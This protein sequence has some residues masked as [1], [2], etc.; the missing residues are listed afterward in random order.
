MKKSE[1]SSKPA[2]VPPLPSDKSPNLSPPDETPSVTIEPTEPTY[3]QKRLQELGITPEL[4]QQTAASFTDEYS[5]QTFPVF[6][7]N[8]NGDILIRYAGINGWKSYFRGKS[9]EAAYIRTRLHPSRCTDGMPK[10]LTPRGAGT[11][12]FFPPLILEAY[13][14]STEIKTLVVTEG[15]FKAFKA[16]IHGLFCVG[17]QGIHNTHEKDPDGGNILNTELQ[18]VIRICKVKNLIFLLDNDCLTVE[19]EED[20][21]LA[22]RP[23]LF[24]SAVRNFREYTKHLDCDVYFAHLNP[25][26]PE[27]G[28]DDLLCAKADK[29]A[30]IIEE[31]LKLKVKNPYFF[32]ENVTD[33]SLKKLKSYFAL[34]NADAFYDKY[35]EVLTDKKFRFSGHYYQFNGL[36]LKRLVSDA[37]NNF[38]RV[39]DDYYEAYHK[40]D[41]EERMELVF[42]KRK[43]STITD[44]Y[45]K[46]ATQF[47]KRYKGFCLVPSHHNYR[48]EINQ[49]YNT[50]Y[51]LTHQPQAG[52]I[53]NSLSLLRHIFGERIEFAVDYMQLLYQRPAQLLPILLLQSKERETG[54]STFGQWLRD[55]FE[56]NSVKL[57]NA[58]LQGDFNSS[59]MEKLLIVVDETS[60]ERKT[61]SE[62]IKRMSTEV[63]KVIVKKKSVAEYE[64]D[65]IGKFVF[66]TNNVGTSLYIGKGETRYAVF[67]VPPFPKEKKDPDMLAKLREE[68]P[69]FLHH[70]QGRTLHYPKIGRMYFDFE[71][72]KTDELDEAIEAN[73]P[74]VEREIRTYIQDCFDTWPYL[75]ELFF[76]PKDLVDELK[77]N[78]KFIDHVSV[79]RTLKNDLEYLPSKESVRYQFYSIRVFSQISDGYAPSSRVGKCYCVNRHFFE[80]GKVQI[81]EPQQ[82]IPF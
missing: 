15:E 40:P 43:K 74:I 80:T 42:D 3:F 47:I 75:K 81:S 44:D 68:I 34:D 33:K 10:Y 37:I 59:F 11:E 30:V 13:Q 48:R 53:E 27:K 25:E 6:S 9:Q 54:K 39:G 41:K 58:D 65:W 26:R 62:A 46:D 8:L 51:P 73:I 78:S 71:V 14:Q 22:K 45:G 77:E 12:V 4:N 18:A 66:C 32:I 70:L 61:T 24:Y 76:T 55:I 38:V 64:T 2:P 50:Y 28:I 19:Y 16:C 7:E 72:Y 21:D 17:V 79:V 57:G 49:C 35:E 36:E 60:L 52:S 5:R 69:A 67:T 82:K 20:K 56:T 31:L 63:G 1:A 23:T 29:A